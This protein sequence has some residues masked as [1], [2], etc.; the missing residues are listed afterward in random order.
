MQRR[1][2]FP[3]MAMLIVGPRTLSAQQLVWNDIEGPGGRYRL[4]LPPGYRHLQVPAH[5]GTL[6]SYLFMLPDKV[7]LELLDL[8]FASP[9]PNF[10]TTPTAL[11]SNLDQVQAGMQRS[12]PGSKLMAQRPVTL[13]ALTGREFV[14]ELPGNRFQLARF[15]L[16]PTQMYVQIAVGPTSEQGSPLVQEFMSSFRLS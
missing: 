12:W 10:P 5:G 1:S 6:N 7:T 8:T 15:Y 3:A 9:P 11:Q 16:E 13:G 2:L 14:L 4:K